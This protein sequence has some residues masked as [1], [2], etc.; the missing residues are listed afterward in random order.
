[1]VLEHGMGSTG[2]YTEH[3]L[4]KIHQQT[5]NEE[6]HNKAHEHEKLSNDEQILTSLNE[7]EHPGYAKESTILSTPGASDLLDFFKENV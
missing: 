2:K 5:H 4:G 7:P 1:M 3:Q 6:G